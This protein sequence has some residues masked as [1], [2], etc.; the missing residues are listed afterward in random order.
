M[1]RRGEISHGKF[2]RDDMGRM[3]LRLGT[4]ILRAKTLAG[5][6]FNPTE[7]VCDYCG[8]RGNCQALA[9]T[10]LKLSHKSGFIVP[11][12]IDLSQATPTDKANLYKL[13]VLMEKWCEDTKKELMRQSTEEGLEMPGYY[14]DQRKVPR[15]IDAPVIAWEALK[16]KLTLQ[17]FLSAATR[18]S[19]SSLESVYSEKAPKGKKGVWKEELNDILQNSSAMKEQGVINVLKA[20]K[21]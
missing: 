15:T 8:N 4:I 20:V 2:T 14:L 1:P 21:A 19:V 5:K 6:E 10:A 13:A 18:I 16:D 9:N 12:S 11:D 17:E 3:S 7:G